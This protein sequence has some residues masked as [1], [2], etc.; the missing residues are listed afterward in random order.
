VRRIF[1]LY[2]TTEL[3]I[4][5]L[6]RQLALEGIAAENGRPISE[7]MLS[8]LLRCEAFIGRFL[9]GRYDHS[10]RRRPLRREETDEGFKR[11]EGM[12][13]PLVDKNIWERS[14]AKRNHCAG[15]VLA[16][17]ELL[18]RLRLALA[19]NPA[20]GLLELQAYGC[21]GYKA[22]VTAFGSFRQAL[23]LAGQDSAAANRLRLAGQLRVHGL[24]KRVTEDVCAL[25]QAD[26]A[27]CS[28]LARHHVLLLSDEVRVRVHVVR[29]RRWRDQLRW[30]FVARRNVPCHFGLLVRMEEDDTAADLLLF[31][32]SEYLGLPK[33]L[34]DE[35]DFVA[36]RLRSAAEVL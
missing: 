22:F 29:R 15:F 24:G 33:W 34:S 14:Q 26:G 31:S 17:E 23:R 32:W 12:F 11:S 8:S 2:A 7:R 1:E 25:L 21:P 3:I 5:A 30:W 19:R 13:Q 10:M 18:R 36:L 20:L 6:A 4:R 28:R 9:W 16:R 35:G 27:H